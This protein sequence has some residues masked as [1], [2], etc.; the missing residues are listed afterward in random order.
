MFKMCRQVAKISHC[1]L[2][3]PFPHMR[4]NDRMPSYIPVNRSWKTIALVTM[5][6]A[7]RRVCGTF[8]IPSRRAIQMGMKGRT[9][10]ILSNNAAPPSMP[11]TIALV[12]ASTALS[13][14]DTRRTKS[15]RSLTDPLIQ[16]DSG[17]RL[18]S[19]SE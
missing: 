13:G 17:K 15:A 8:D 9:S 12:A 1:G 14:T 4:S 16:P 5:A 18:S 2:V 3:D 7:M 11:S 10:S 6:Q 19:G